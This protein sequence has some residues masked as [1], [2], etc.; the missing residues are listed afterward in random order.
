MGITA[1]TGVSLHETLNPAEALGEGFWVPAAGVVL[2]KRWE[3]WDATASLEGRLSLGRSF[4]L[5]F[6]DE[7]T[8]T[9][10]FGNQIG[11]GGL[12]AVGFSPGGGNL[13]FGARL[14]PQRDPGTAHHLDRC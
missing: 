12:I 5:S 4:T 11:V 6:D 7:F 3:Q 8:S 13:R 10:Q 14:E 9:S 1:P 2:V